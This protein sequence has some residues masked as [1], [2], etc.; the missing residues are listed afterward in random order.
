MVGDGRRH[1]QPGQECGHKEA[2]PTHEK[3]GAKGDDDPRDTHAVGW[4]GD[5]RAERVQ[6]DGNR[7]QQGAV[8]R[9]VSSEPP[10]H[11]EDGEE[12]EEIHQEGRKHR[13]A[14]PRPA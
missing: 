1:P 13:Y 14:G 8:A 7:P 2:T 6:I 9:S 10:S 4:T 3:K 11:Q 12:A 5:E